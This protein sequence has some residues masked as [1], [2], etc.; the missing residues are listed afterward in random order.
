MSWV[1][2]V[3]PDPNRIE[4]FHTVEGPGMANEW[5]RERSIRLFPDDEPMPNGVWRQ[6]AVLEALLDI[7]YEA[8]KRAR[9]EEIMKLLKG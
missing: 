5:T 7:A 3:K 2:K 6:R 1:Y 4:G 9:S 8:G